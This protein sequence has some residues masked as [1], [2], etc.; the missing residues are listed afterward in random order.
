MLTCASAVAAPDWV[1]AI[2]ASHLGGRARPASVARYAMESGGGFILDTSTGKALLKFQDG[3]E[4]WALTVSRGPRGDL[5]YWNDIR[6]P[7]LRAT[8]LGGVTVF[9]P[10]RPEGDAATATGP[11]AALHISGVGLQGLYQRLLQ[12]AARSSH[13]A[14]HTIVYEARDDNPGAYGVMADAALV[15]SE[16]IVFIASRPSGRLQLLRLT[17]VRILAGK[18]AGGQLKEGVLTLTVTPARDAFG[19]PSS[20]RIAQVLEGH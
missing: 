16:A 2:F 12:A 1:H 17:K 20:L 18:D 13:A 8:R 7:L 9:T 11:G 15:A 6:Q 3:F 10:H 19:R 14:A 5:I 4:V